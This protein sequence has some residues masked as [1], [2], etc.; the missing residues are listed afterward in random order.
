M[1]YDFR[2]TSVPVKSFDLSVPSIDASKYRTLKFSIRAREEG[3]PGVVK[4]VFKN[5]LN[6]EDAYY[7]KGV[8]MSWKDF[9]ISLDEL[10]HITDWTN[11]T[12]VSF[13]LE[14]WNVEKQRGL[15]LIDDVRFATQS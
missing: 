12:D 10:K 9:E 14:S 15:I 8:D 2:G 4:I 13:V 5:R 6:E 1:P 7:V 3:S 11:L